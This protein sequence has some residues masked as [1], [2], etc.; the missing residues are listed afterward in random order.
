MA[1]GIDLGFVALEVSQLAAMGEKLR[2]S[3]AGRGTPSS[4]R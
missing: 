4:A 3:P 2:K 1:V